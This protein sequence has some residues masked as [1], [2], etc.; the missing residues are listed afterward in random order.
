MNKEIQL[1]DLGNK[2][3]KETWDYQE[4]LFK[5]I[6]DVKLEKRNNPQLVTPN[7]FLFVEHPQNN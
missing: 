1:R 2:D 3:Y 4:A 6:M 5:E 7:Y